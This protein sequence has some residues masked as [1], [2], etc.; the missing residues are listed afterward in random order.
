MSSGREYHRT[1]PSHDIFFFNGYLID[2]GSFHLLDDCLGDLLMFFHQHLICLFVNDVGGCLLP[3]EK[4]RGVSL[5]S[6][7]IFND[8]F[9]FLI[10]IIK[11]LFFGIP[12]SFQE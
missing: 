12:E 9:F 2:I 6:L 5:K 7:L 10:K 8:D 1:L 4:W 3:D 11:D